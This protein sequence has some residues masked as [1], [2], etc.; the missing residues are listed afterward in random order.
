MGRAAICKRAQIIAAFKGGNQPASTGYFGDL[1]K[2]RGGP[3]IVVLMEPQRSQR[4]GLMGVEASRNKDKLGHK[5]GQG[6]QNPVVHGGA[7]LGRSGHGRQRGVNDICRRSRARSRCRSLD[8]VASGESNRKNSD[9]SFQNIAWVPLP[10]W[11]SKSTTATRSRPYAC[12]AWAPPTATLLNR[13][14]PM[15]RVGSA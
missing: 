2:P 3:G 7:E 11:T 14:K 10:W 13:Q 4:V 8:R 6:R 15:A 1:Q 12:F 9:G 5:S